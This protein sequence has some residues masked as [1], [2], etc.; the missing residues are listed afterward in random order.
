MSAI[1]TYHKQERT[2]GSATETTIR[3]DGT[4]ERIETAADGT[5]TRFV[6]VNG[7]WRPAG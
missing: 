3:A 7:A 1:V 2:D 4:G 5:E 6:L